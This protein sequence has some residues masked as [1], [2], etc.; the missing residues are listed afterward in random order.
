MN[1]VVSRQFSTHTVSKINQQINASLQ[2][3]KSSQAHQRW[4]RWREQRQATPH[5]QLHEQY[6]K[7]G[8]KS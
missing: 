2:S 3:L 6:R 8:V 5:M 7:V 4:R 1:E